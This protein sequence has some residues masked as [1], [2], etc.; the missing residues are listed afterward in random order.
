MKKEKDMNLWFSLKELLSKSPSW[1]RSRRGIIIVFLLLLAI[2]TSVMVFLSQPKDS[3]VSPLLPTGTTATATQSAIPGFTMVLSPTT[4]VVP[5]PVAINHYT[6]A[7]ALGEDRFLIV[8]SE[9]AHIWDGRM[10]RAMPM[11]N[12]GLWIGNL[13][14][15]KVGDRVLIAGERLPEGVR[16]DPKLGGWNV[17]WNLWLYD[18]NTENGVDVKLA[19]PRM[20]YKIVALSENEA[21]VVGGRQPGDIYSKQGTVIGMPDVELIGW[22]QIGTPRV[23]SLP[24]MQQK[25]WS[26]GLVRLHD[27]WVMAVGGWNLASTEIFNRQTL[28]WISAEPYSSDGKGEVEFTLSTLPDNRLVMFGYDN[29]RIFDPRTGHW[30]KVGVPWGS[31]SIGVIHGDNWVFAYYPSTINNITYLLDFHTGMTRAGPVIQRERKYAVV[32]S[33]SNGEIH[34]LGGEDE[35]GHQLMSVEILRTD[36]SSAVEAGLLEFPLASTVPAKLSDGRILLAGNWGIYGNDPRKAYIVEATAREA[37][38]GR[39]DRD[40]NYVARLNPA[41]VSFTDG[42]QKI[43]PAIGFRP[44]AYTMPDGSVVVVGGLRPADKPGE[45]PVIPAQRWDP[46]TGQWSLVPG[47]N[48]EASIMQEGGLDGIS[49]IPNITQLSNGDLVFFEST[50][51]LDKTKIRHWRWTTGELHNLGILP[52]WRS[53]FSALEFVDGR[54]AVVGGKEREYLIALE[55]DCTACPDEYVPYGNVQD[56]AGTDIYDFATGQWQS[57]PRSRYPGG[58][59]VRLA[60]GRI[61]KVASVSDSTRVALEI[62]NAAFT[63]WTAVSPPPG[64]GEFPILKAVFALGKRV[65]LF[66]EGT[67]PERPAQVWNAET[68]QW[69][70]WRLDRAVPYNYALVINDKTLFLLGGN[71][72]FGYGALLYEAVEV[73]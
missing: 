64:D 39:H 51:L 62:S 27:G 63:Q 18:P 38:F 23:K 68:A 42:T 50:A 22:D 4:E 59:A 26:H 43:L 28:K 16:R 31:G 34:I 49:Q 56:A 41:S 14:V 20:D 19:V 37:V 9:E 32:V 35:K 69:N 73:P 65:V 10:R 55:K 12:V 11:K 61:V 60:D 45:L 72:Y 52:Y 70:L 29:L 8:G 57:G 53:G 21:L 5:I 36:K 25:R 66:R 71:N 30:S 33:L 44:S 67:G 54:I 47:L 3:A 2:G 13:E 46:H 1:H 58:S 7:V 6:K 15:V 48:F 17:L 40:H 24:G